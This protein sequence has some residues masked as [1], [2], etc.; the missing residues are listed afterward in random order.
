[1][2]RAAVDDP[3]PAVRAEAVGALS[4]FLAPEHR[5]AVETCTADS[6]ARVRA[7]AAETMG[8]FG[9]KAATGVL[10]K[11][12]ETDPA[13]QVSQAALRGLVGCDDPR[14]IVT[15]LEMAGRGGS[16]LTKITAMKGLLA[17]YKGRLLLE[18]DDP[19]DAEKW[20]GLVQKLKRLNSIR[21]AYAAAGV[22][23]GERP[24]DAGHD[25]HPERRK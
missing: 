14:A 12:A 8:Q 25:Y 16:R 15:L 2:A 9:D 3:S 7:V 10:V 22:P 20:R 23:L 18:R 13:E 24:A 5:G 21:D 6:E 1:M 4:H 17:K 11:L 19:D